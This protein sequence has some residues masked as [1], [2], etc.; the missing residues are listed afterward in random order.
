MKVI[1][2]KETTYASLT[3]KV[4]KEATTLLASCFLLWP[5]ASSRL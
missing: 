4:N 1:T 3:I 5:A 2:T